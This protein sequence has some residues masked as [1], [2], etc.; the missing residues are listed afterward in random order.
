MAKS[1]RPSPHAL[2]EKYDG[3]DGYEGYADD[4][5]A[6]NDA[7]L[8]AFAPIR[9]LPVVVHPLPDYTR[10]T[11]E[12]PQILSKQVFFRTLYS[13]LQSTRDVINCHE[14]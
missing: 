14:F 6:D 1:E 9:G 10:T 4:R 8:K 3:E 12:V 2:H 13:C 7:G 11:P 5:G